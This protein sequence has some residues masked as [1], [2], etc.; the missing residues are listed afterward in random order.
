MAFPRARVACGK[1]AIALPNAA[2][3]TTIIPG[4]SNRSIRVTDFWL[5]AIGGTVGTATSIDLQSAGTAVSI[6]VGTAANLTVAA[7]AVRAG[8]TGMAIGAGFNAD[9]PHGEGVRLITV[10]SDATTVTHIE[11]CRHLRADVG[12]HHGT[13]TSASSGG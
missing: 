6:G 10:G 12:R 2:A 9:L 13:P 1:A 5:R 11:Y 7:G 8:A 4:E 3:G